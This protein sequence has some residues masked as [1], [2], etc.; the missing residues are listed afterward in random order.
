MVLRVLHAFALL[1]GV[2]GTFTAGAVTSP[3]LVLRGATVADGSG[4]TPLRDATIVIQGG[5]NAAIGRSAAVHVPRGART[6]ART[7]KYVIPGLMDGNVH[8]DFGFAPEYLFA[9]EG[10]Y[11]ELILEAAQVALK[12]GVTTVFDSWGPRE[13]LAK[14]RD[15]INANRLVGSRMFIAGNIIGAGGPTSSDFLAPLRTVI[16]AADAD[17]IDAMWEQG[18]G[19]DLLWMTPEEVREKVRAYIA[20]GHLDFVKYLSSGHKDMQFIAFSPD[21][22]QR[23]SRKHM[24]P[25]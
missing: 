12:N 22:K 1:L 2:A 9:Y 20:T 6:V 8:L 7:G 19:P 3:P 23:S 4:G 14:V 24:A 25:G 10:R 11:D 5:R 13:S 15:S 18:V 17:R 16:N 21:A